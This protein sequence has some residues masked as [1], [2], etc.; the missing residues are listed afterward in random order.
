[1]SGSI[2]VV[3]GPPGVGKTTVAERVQ[4]R[5]GGRLFRTDAVRKSIFPEPTYSPEETDAVYRALLDRVER[6]IADGRAIADGHSQQVLDEVAPPTVESDVTTPVESD[7]LP[8]VETPPNALVAILDG[9]FRSSDRRDA[10]RDLGASLDVSVTFLRVTCS[11][12]VVRSRIE[13]REG[14]SDAD[15]EI[16]RQIKSEFE[17]IEA[18]HAVI[19]NSDGRA[20]TYRCV[21]AAL[22]ASSVSNAFDL[23]LE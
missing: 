13:S 3:C 4:Q 14:L 23:T 7:A 15:Y 9:T 19:D 1:M 10:V 20:D 12:S 17:P 11:D 2:V 18:D 21:D 5:T 16:Y 22:D 6:T 8:T